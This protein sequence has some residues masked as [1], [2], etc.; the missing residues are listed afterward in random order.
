MMSP[1]SNLAARFSV[2]LAEW[3]QGV[4]LTLIAC[5]ASN[6]GLIFQKLSNKRNSELAPEDRVAINSAYAM[7]TTKTQFPSDTE[8][9]FT[10]LQ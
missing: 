10:H 5:L 3:Q 8:C 9:A 7:K 4:I 2:G 1:F 6:L